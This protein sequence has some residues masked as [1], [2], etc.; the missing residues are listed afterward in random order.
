VGQ[1]YTHNEAVKTMG[2]GFSTIGKWV[3]QLQQEREGVRVKQ[4]PMTPEQLSVIEK[5]SQCD[6]R[7]Y[8]IKLLCEVFEVH[9]I[10]TQILRLF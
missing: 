5:L 1:G 8:S 2:V 9:H 7:R 6:E 3:K 4:T 10:T